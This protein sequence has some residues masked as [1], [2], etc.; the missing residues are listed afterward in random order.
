[1]D[2]LSRFCQY[3]TM[4]YVHKDNLTLIVFEYSV[5]YIYSRKTG[6]WIYKIFSNIIRVR[7]LIRY[8]NVYYESIFI[9]WAHWNHVSQTT[10]QSAPAVPNYVNMNSFVNISIFICEDR[11]HAFTIP[12][13]GTYGQCF[14]FMGSVS[15]IV[16][17]ITAR[18][19]PVV[20]A[21]HAVPKFVTAQHSMT[22]QK[23]PAVK[24]SRQVIVPGLSMH[25]LRVQPACP[26]FPQKQL[27]QSSL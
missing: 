6:P 8:C 18:D 7:Y 15:Q 21:S 13:C 14:I 4:I 11:R 5:L 9:N 12:K 22:G 17:I 10:P 25:S 20:I 1:M 23:L 16:K 19:S 2:C 26:L 27:L 3:Q 24:V